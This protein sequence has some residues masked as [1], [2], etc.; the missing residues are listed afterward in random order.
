MSQQYRHSADEEWRIHT[1]IFQNKHRECGE[2]G[3]LWKI[4]QGDGDAY[5]RSRRKNDVTCGGLP[6]RQRNEA[7]D[8][9]RKELL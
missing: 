1:D 4:K 3:S 6:E 8:A 2:I 7:R 9:G 5:F